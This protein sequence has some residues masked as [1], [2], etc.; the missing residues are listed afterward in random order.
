MALNELQGIINSN[1]MHM[2]RYAD[3]FLVFCKTKVDADVKARALVNE[4]LASRGLE[5]NVEKTK[6]TEISDKSGIEFLGFKIREYPDSTRKK[7]NVLLITP[8]RKK[9]ETLLGKTKLIFRENRAKSV[10]RVINELNP[11]LRGWANYFRTGVSKRV[12][13]YIGYK[14]YSQTK[15][16]L[17]HKYRGVPVRKLMSK[18]FHTV[19]KNRWVLKSYDPDRGCLVS[20]F[21]IASVPIQRHQLSLWENPFFP[22]NEHLWFKPKAKRTKPP[23]VLNKRKQELFRKQKAICVHCRLLMDP[24]EEILE[25]HHVIPRSEG[26]EDDLRNLRLLHRVCHL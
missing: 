1:G 26:G 19:N 23:I 4:F 11:I 22:K 10:H 5:L 21:Q 18:H 12:F 20:L 16:Y 6:V 2:V 25:E 8:Q 17:L 7:G 15:S 24:L 14:L 9:V 3:D 13:T